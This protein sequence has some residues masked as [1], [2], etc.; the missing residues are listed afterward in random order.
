MK[1][2]PVEREI[3]LPAFADDIKIYWEGPEDS[4]KKT[5]NKNQKQ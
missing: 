3:K 2:I 1:G 5:K 4:V